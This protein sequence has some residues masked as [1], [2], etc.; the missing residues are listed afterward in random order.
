MVNSKNSAMPPDWTQEQMFVLNRVMASRQ[1]ARCDTL[2]KI[3]AFLAE[4]S[5]GPH[6]PALKEY[7]IAVEALGRSN[8][9]DPRLDP[10]VRVSVASIRRRLQAF[11]SSEGADC[12]LRIEI[13]RG[14]YRLCFEP[15]AAPVTS[16]ARSALEQFWEPYLRSEAPTLIV[17]TEPLFFHDRSSLYIRDLTVN[18]AASGGQELQRRAPFLSEADLQPVYHYLS[19]GE[20][21]CM[22]SLTRFLQETG[23]SVETRNCR[24]L[25]W[26]ELSRAN[27]ILLGSPRTNQFVSRLQDDWPIRVDADSIAVRSRG[28]GSE[29][30]LRGSY[31]HDGS[32]RRMTEYAAVTRRAGIAP[33]RVLT[34]IAANH[35]RAIEGAGHALVLEDQ[36]TEVLVQLR[37]SPGAPLPGQFQLLMRVETTD[38][39]EEVSSVHCDE[40]VIW[41]TAPRRRYP[42]MSP[43]RDEPPEP[44]PQ[45]A[46]Q[47]G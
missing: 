46:E 9:F 39:D 43:R 31:Y 28:K 27:L 15:A 8:T 1:F 34:I 25:Q 4:R 26:S 22:L 38:I 18:D 45:L 36:V 13:P 35:G 29:R 17:F 24:H 33:G 3:L 37:V 21:Y 11:F 32:L 12:T 47:C 16:R 42:R 20:M 40:A 30:I 14:E 41:N 2:K 23:V 5:G 44:P 7:E 19:A 6:E 10:I